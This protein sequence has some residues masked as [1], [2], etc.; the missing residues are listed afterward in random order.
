VCAVSC[1]CLAEQAREAAGVGEWR[2][3]RFGCSAV[4]VS[5]AIVGPKQHV[6]YLE[7]TAVH[8]AVH[9]VALI[10][11]R[12]EAAAREGAKEAGPSSAVRGNCA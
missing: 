9:S 6:R 4:R 10:S 2:R 12:I 8:R 5:S 11:R 1:D 7:S 3:G